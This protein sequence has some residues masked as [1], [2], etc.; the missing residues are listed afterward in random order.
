MKEN[1]LFP[2]ERQRWCRGIVLFCALISALLVSLLSVET[3]HSE[4][5]TNH[6]LRRQAFI[7]KIKKR[8]QPGIDRAKEYL[9]HSGRPKRWED[10]RGVYELMAI[11]NGQ[12][13][14]YMTTNVNSAI[15]IAADIVRND[16]YYWMSGE[17]LTA[18]VWDAGVALLTHQELVGRVVS[19]DGAGANWHSTMV[20]GTLA[21]TGIDPNATGMAPLIN[22]DGYNW[23]NDEAEMA[24]VAMELP[25]QPTGK[26]QIS[27]H[28]YGTSCGWRKVSTSPDVWYW[29]G[30]SSYQESFLFGAYLSSA[31]SFDDICYRYPY[32]LPF[33]GAGNDRWDTSRPAEG[34]TYYVNETTP[35]IFYATTGP[36][37]D[38]GPE[39]G[40]FDTLM[41][42]ACA[43][44]VLTIGA[45]ND[46]VT[47]G[48][49]DLSKATIASMS[50]W[51]PTDDG[52]VK[53]DLV[54]N[55]VTVYSCYSSNNT[56]YSTTSGTSLSSPAAAGAGAQLLDLYGQL[57]SGQYIRSSTLKALMIHTADN[58]GNPGPDYKF[59]WGLVNN[60]KSAEKLLLHKRN[61]SANNII[62]DSLRQS[63]NPNQRD[64]EDTFTFQWDGV[65]PIKATLCYTDPAGSST[66]IGTPDST[67]K[68]LV[69]DLD[70]V[71]TAP[72]GT[73][74]YDEFVLDPANP[75]DSATTGNNDRDNVKQVLIESPPQQ[76]TYTIR[77]DYDNLNG[78]QVYT[79]I[80][81][82][83]AQPAIYDVDGN[84]EIGL[85]DLILLAQYWMTDNAACDI[86]PAVGDSSVDLLDFALLSQ[87]WLQ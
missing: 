86:Y 26:I 21:A 16:P 71:I 62:V 75:N 28:S 29:Y 20:T 78:T 3:A 43:K 5:D 80:I 55:G 64:L 70:I 85:G 51:G 52:R 11:E 15:S 8:R 74:I 33:R 39:N 73:T 44:N 37:A 30:N 4:P 31:S 69:Y 42:D 27:N 2:A 1:F 83:Q 32:F 41:P 6:M 34:E 45:V 79:L 65:S 54:T 38:N 25:D 87:G 22:I 67:L 50:A 19:K 82:G 76:G 48:S 60:E 14:V 53:P 9:R 56:S 49:R 58:L 13:I 18:G 47:D 12:P 7:E 24:A 17:G 66:V 77:V 68:K 72:D 23:T 61:P 10:D 81:S 84:G 46:A 40:G 35:A 36:Y 57:F 59:G 63:Y